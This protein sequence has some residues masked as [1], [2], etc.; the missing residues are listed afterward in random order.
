MENNQETKNYNA[1][2]EPDVVTGDQGAAED[3]KE[4]MGEGVSRTEC[5]ERPPRAPRA[6]KDKGSLHARHHG[7]LSRNPMQALIRLGENPRELLK[8]EKMLREELKPTGIVGK[9]LFDRAWS[10]FL[11]C[12]LIART[13]ARLFM[14]VSQNDSD[15]MPELKVMELPTLVWSEAGATNYGFSDDLMKHLETAL[16]YDAHY[17]REFYRAVGLLVGMQTGGLTGL[18]DCL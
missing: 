7:V 9:I 13:E 4:R 3:G 18:L 14:A 1:Q 12:L 15:Q 2:P 10:S 11:R 6:R 16:R 8:I 17:A 5:P